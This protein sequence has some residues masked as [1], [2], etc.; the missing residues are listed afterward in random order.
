MNGSATVI[1]SS[2]ADVALASVEMALA[3][4]T[5]PP[6]ATDMAFR[7]CNVFSR[8]LTSRRLAPALLAG[9]QAACSM[10]VDADRA[11]CESDADCMTGPAAL[12][13]GACVEGLC[14]ARAEW[15]CGA[16]LDAA[17]LAAEGV[18]VALPVVDLAPRAPG[19]SVEASL[20]HKYDVSCEAPSLTMR[21][22]ES[23]ELLL[24]IEPGFDGYLSVRGD[25]LVPT[26]YFLSQPL[27]TGE[28]LP[29]LTLLSPALLDAL[30]LEMHVTLL[31]DRGLGL[32][33]IQ[34]CSGTFSS[35]V[36]FEAQPADEGTVAFYDVDGLPTASAT[37][38]G[39]TGSG[40]FINAPAGPL[41]VTARLETGALPVASASV[42]IR[43]G[44][45]SHG[46]LMPPS[47]PGV[48]P[49][50]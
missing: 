7:S 17:T 6:P 47:V 18:E 33:T 5:V 28:R 14:E 46:R 25:E 30:A 16:T 43:P 15:G 2:L 3:I 32:F 37:S 34:D 42:L 1:T 29:A 31:P 8:T 20:C 21:M 9:L 39:R 19:A 10:M 38:T 13:A 40:G 48:A 41:T 12:A 35:G 11:Q 45:V 27:V 36:A 24:H 26:L 44:F 49:S 22:D 4:G 23:D 50:P